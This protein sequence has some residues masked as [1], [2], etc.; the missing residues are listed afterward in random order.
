MK[1]LYQ[2]HAGSDGVITYEEMCALLFQ[3]GSGV[4]DNKNPVY[5]MAKLNS[6][7]G[8]TQGMTKKLI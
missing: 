6:G 5:E 7:L 2:K 8:T 1:V 3:M 4:K